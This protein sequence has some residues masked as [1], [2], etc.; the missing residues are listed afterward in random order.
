MKCVRNNDFDTMSCTTIHSTSVCGSDKIIWIH[1]EGYDQR[2]Y[3]PK[4]LLFILKIF[5][6]YYSGETF[7]SGTGYE[8]HLFTLF[9]CGKDTRINPVIR[10]GVVERKKKLGKIWEGTFTRYVTQRGRGCQH[11]TLRL[12][13][14]LLNSIVLALH[15]GRM[16]SKCHFL[17]L[18]T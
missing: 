15:R 6:E 18:H 10:G 4:R 12:L 17:A 9:C 14:L 16:W 8:F 3:L 7:H 1:F 11:F 5:W 13:F 2:S